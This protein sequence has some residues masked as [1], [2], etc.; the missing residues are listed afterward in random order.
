M[1][2]D[3]N[4][5]RGPSPPR[6]AK[7]QSTDHDSTI[8][9]ERR[10]RVKRSRSAAPEA[11]NEEQRPRLTTPDLEFDYDQSQLRDPRPTPGRVRRPR[12]RESEVSEEFK[13]RFFIPKPERPK[14][15]LNAHQKE[16]LYSEQSFLDPA[17]TFHDLYVCY[18]R[19]PHGQPTYDSAGF[20]LDFDKVAEWMK[21]QAYNKQRIVRGAMRAVDRAKREEQELFN[22]FFVPGDQPDSNHG[23]DVTNHVKD[24]I[25][26]D[27]GIPWHQINAQRAREWLDKGFEQ[28]KFSEWWQKPNKEEGKR[29]LNMLG[30]GSLR[31]DL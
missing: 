17:Q 7:R 16:W 21:P 15:R 27:L 12:L 2:T 3:A 30:G 9:V 29:M 6:G 20:Q 13:Q 10:K 5:Y 8:K 11:S 24:H 25:S 18:R 26:K 14:G 31:K 4:H 22:S 28:K 23:C 1:P 19:G